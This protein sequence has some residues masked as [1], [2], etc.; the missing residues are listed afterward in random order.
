LRQNDL[1]HKG[2]LFGSWGNFRLGITEKDLMVSYEMTGETESICGA[3]ST[4][5]GVSGTHRRIQGYRI[6]AKL[7]YVNNATDA[8]WQKLH[9]GSNMFF[10]RHRPLRYKKAPRLI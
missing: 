6:L 10:E 7:P 4:R 3:D 2:N 5:I 8:I 9:T 1:N